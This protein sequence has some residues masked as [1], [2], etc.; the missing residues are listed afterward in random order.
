MAHYAASK[1]GVIALTK[2]LAR[3]YAP[4]GI[5]VNTI[6]PSGI[7]TPMQ[8]R[9]QAEGHLPANDVIEIFLID[10]E[11]TV[12]AGRHS[13][14]QFIIRDFDIDSVYFRTWSHYLPGFA[15]AEIED[16]SDHLLLF[17]QKKSFFG[18]LADDEFDLFDCVQTGMPFGCRYLE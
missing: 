18:A 15:L 9:S 8:H 6:P 3:E 1:G 4:Y 2:S 17:F 13:L 5:T 14:Q 11:S 16:L 12:P 7:E 10:R